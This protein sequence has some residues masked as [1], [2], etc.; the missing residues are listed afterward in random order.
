VPV[1]P[2]IGVTLPGLLGLPQ[3]DLGLGGDEDSSSATPSQ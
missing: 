3:I 2:S 1:L